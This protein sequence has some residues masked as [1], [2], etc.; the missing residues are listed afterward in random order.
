[1]RLPWAQPPPLDVA[2]LRV[3]VLGAARSG[4]GC[5]RLLTRSG[6][7]VIVGDAM[8]AEALDPQSLE[9]ISRTGAELRFEVAGLAQLGPVDL[10]V[11][12]PGVPI[13]APLLEQARAAGVRI[14]G[15]VEL[16]Y[17]FSRAPIIAIAGTNAKGSTCTLT[18]AMLN[19]SGVRARVCGNIGD[20]FTGAIAEEEPPKVYVLEISS[21]QLETIE[22]FRPSVAC[23][24]NISNDHLDRHGSLEAYIAAK[25]RLF[26]NQAADDWAVVNADDPNVARAAEGA[27]ARRIRFSATQPGVEARVEGDRLLVDLG[28]GP[29]PVCQKGDLVRW[30]APYIETVLAA[31]SAALVAGARHEGLLEAIR[32]HRLPPEVLEFVGEARGVRFVNSSKATNPAAA[33]ADI[34]SVPGPLVVIAGGLE[35]GSDFTE[36]GEVLRRRAKAAFLLGQCAERIAEAAAGV[37]CTRCSTLEEAV[38]GAFAA[39]A[40]GDTVLL[41]PACASW[42]MFK[43]YKVRGAQFRE[44]ARRVCDHDDRGIPDGG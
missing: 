26:E 24:L 33:I 27:S 16:G 5:S 36:F 7:R 2:G 29:E 8:P 34:D 6:A 20:P 23:L 30:G 41:A 42:D 38:H 37:E 21:F 39:A 9:Q 43:D 25:D 32:T 17:R 10:L 15:E 18:G 19:C 35:R 14:T 12:S 44:A 11:I 40:P 4:V 3:A 1:M 31:A 28:D 13:N 22:H